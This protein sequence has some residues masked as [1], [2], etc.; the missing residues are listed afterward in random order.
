VSPFKV[1]ELL[2]AIIRICCPDPS[3]ESW[4]SNVEIVEDGTYDG[5]IPLLLLVPSTTH[6]RT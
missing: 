4:I 1:G 2:S 3:E 6:L 5:S